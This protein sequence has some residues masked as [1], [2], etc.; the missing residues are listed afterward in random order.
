MDNFGGRDSEDE[1]ISSSLRIARKSRSVE[2]A[3][4]NT[5]KCA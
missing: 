3:P 1:K 2:C 4:N 5:E